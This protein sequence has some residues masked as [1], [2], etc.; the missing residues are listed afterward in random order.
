VRIIL[1]LL[2]SKSI[3]YMISYQEFENFEPRFTI[4]SCYAEFEGKFILLK[5]LPHK[6]N[7]GMWGLPAGK[8]EANESTEEG[9]A[10][11]L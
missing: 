11:E 5:R 7:G 9:A 6:V 1:Q 4:V 10:R 8:L 2:A 3:N